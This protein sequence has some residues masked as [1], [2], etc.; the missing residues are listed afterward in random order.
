MEIGLGGGLANPSSSCNEG[1]QDTHFT[2]AFAMGMPPYRGTEATSLELLN[3][4][5]AG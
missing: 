3:D 2:A 1:V 5:I 4:N